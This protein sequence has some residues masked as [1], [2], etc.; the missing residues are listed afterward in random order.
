MITIFLYLSVLVLHCCAQKGVV[1]DMLYEREK[2]DEVVRDL[3][4]SAQRDCLKEVRFTTVDT[5]MSY[6]DRSK[7]VNSEALLLSAASLW[8]H[9]SSIVLSSFTSKDLNVIM[10]IPLA[11]SH[12]NIGLAKGMT[13]GTSKSMQLAKITKVNPMLPVHHPRQN[14]SY[15]ANIAAS[16]EQQPRDFYSQLKKD[17]KLSYV[18][19]LQNGIIHK[20]GFVRLQCGWIQPRQGCSSRVLSNA[21]TWDKNVT[22][23]FASY[24]DIHHSEVWTD[25]NYLSLALDHHSPVYDKVFV[26]GTF[27]D[28]NYHHILHESLTRLIRFYHF[29]RRHPEVYIHIMAGE[30]YFNATLPG[31]RDLAVK[32]RKLRQRVFELV[33]IPQE[34]IITGEVVARTIY[35]PNDIECGSSFRHSL[36][37]KLLSQLLVTRAQRVVKDGGCR[38]C[39]A[40][41]TYARPFQADKNRLSPVPTVLKSSGLKVVLQSRACPLEYSE[42]EPLVF[43][44]NTRPAKAHWRCFTQ[45]QMDSLTDKIPQHFPD[46]ETII[47][48]EPRLCQTGKDDPPPSLA[49]DI[50]LYRQADVSIGLHGAAMTNVMFMRPGTVLV[51]IVGGY[52]GRMIPVCGIFGPLA[53]V[54]GVHHYIYYYDGVLDADSL[55]IG[56]VLGKAKEFIDVIRTKVTAL[57]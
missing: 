48:G 2:V 50:A 27:W 51:E 22:A 3:K 6:L 16:V 57:P 24:K 46:S 1:R 44:N 13:N 19:I 11:I 4:F 55:D 49:C 26:I 56:D 18:R 41:T 12:S 39:P 20:D 25:M 15:C 36:E 31:Q 7:D 47:A 14:M 37:L 8:N 40:T 52:D 21:R 43:A 45:R 5:S 23:R 29:L 38:M 32:S 10:N 54:Y 33:G 53:A 30:D 42:A 9:T 28:F 35:L 17:Y 34:R